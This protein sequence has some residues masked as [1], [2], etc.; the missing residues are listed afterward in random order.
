MTK[1]PTDQ[2]IDDLWDD[3]GMYFNLYDQ[4]RDTVREALRLWGNQE[5]NVSD[6]HTHKELYENETSH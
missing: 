2:Q 3:I 5:S 4:V 1:T 6:E